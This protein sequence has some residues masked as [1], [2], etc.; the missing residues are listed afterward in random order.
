MSYKCLYSRFHI[1]Q[2][3]YIL[4]WVP[5]GF[6]ISCKV[7]EVINIIVFNIVNIILKTI[8]PVS[9]DF[10]T[11]LGGAKSIIFIFYIILAI[12]FD[13]ILLI[14]GLELITYFLSK[15]NKKEF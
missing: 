9:F 12:V 13:F 6:I 11:I 7:S 2:I 8:F 4:F 3:V 10:F 1:F 14:S 15:K 5:V